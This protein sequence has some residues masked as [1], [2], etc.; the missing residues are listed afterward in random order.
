MSAVPDDQRGSRRTLQFPY[1]EAPKMGEVREIVPGILWAC[2]PLPFAL[3]HVNVYFIEDGKGWA[4]FDNG[5]F[6]KKMCEFWEQLLAGPLGGRPITKVIVSHHHPDHIGMSGWLCEKYDAPLLISQTA[7]LMCVNLSLNPRQD[8]ASFYYDFYRRYGMEEETARLIT[9]SGHRYLT[10]VSELPE[11]FLRLLSGDELY[12]GGR[13]CRVLQGDGHAPEQIM[14]YIPDE[15]ILLAADQ[16]MA[17]ISPNVSVWSTDPDSDPLGHFL[18]SLRLLEANIPGDPLVLAGHKL[19]F[20][21]LHQRCRE[22]VAH[23]DE[24]CAII[25][26]ACLKGP[27]SVADLVPYV[28]PRELDPQQHGFAFSEVHAHVN[29]MIRRGEVHWIEPQDGVYRIALSGMLAQ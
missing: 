10:M 14:L 26:E 8:R 18:R 15:N 21:G 24:R 9:T 28:F 3:N 13:R 20:Y 29:R 27:K 19:P 17:K 25:A 4:V 11:T 12:I 22:L 23:H 16:V 7:Y 6:S 2:L 1:E 5:V